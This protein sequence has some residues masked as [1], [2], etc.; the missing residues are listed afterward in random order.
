[1][2]EI[3]MI[4]LMKEADGKGTFK[5]PGDHCK[6]SPMFVRDENTSLI[7]LFNVSLHGITAVRDDKLR[8]NS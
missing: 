8:I 4:T 2:K 3:M 1:M 7:V 5:G 6:C